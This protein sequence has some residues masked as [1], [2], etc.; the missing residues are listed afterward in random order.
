MNFPAK[1]VLS[2]LPL[3]QEKAKVTLQLVMNTGNI[4]TATLASLEDRILRMFMDLERD[5]VRLM[6][7]ELHMDVNNPYSPAIGHFRGQL[8]N[9]TNTNSQVTD[10]RVYNEATSQS[11]TAQRNC[12]KFIQVTEA[13]PWRC[14]QP[15][16][17]TIVTENLRVPTTVQNV[18]LLKSMS[19]SESPE[20]LTAWMAFA[21]KAHRD[22]N[23][24]SRTS[25]EW[26]TPSGSQRQ[27]AI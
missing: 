6:R 26:T 19:E 5:C 18:A 1:A 16:L 25:L 23:I 24:G 15:N 17:A 3:K 2:D 21:W 8:T 13:D 12:W 22:P 10:S 20:R 4:Q 14:C 11:Q 7:R 27:S 9:C